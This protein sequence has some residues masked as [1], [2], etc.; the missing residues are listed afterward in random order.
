VGRGEHCAIQYGQYDLKSHEII[1]KHAVKLTAWGK[2]HR[3][4]SGQSPKE[5]RVLVNVSG[6]VIGSRLPNP[7]IPTLMAYESHG[8]DKRIFERVYRIMEG[9]E[10][11]HDGCLFE[12]ERD[13]TG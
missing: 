12:G 7:L 1:K 6:E 5:D 4:Y 13:G 9:T 10:A 2:T 8:T 11:H 3:N